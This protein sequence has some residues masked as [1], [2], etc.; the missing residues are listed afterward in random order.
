MKR[1]GLIGEAYN[2]NTTHM[3]YCSD[4]APFPHIWSKSAFSGK[5][6]YM[7]LTEV[8]N[9][10]PVFATRMDQLLFKPSDG[11]KSALSLSS[12]TYFACEP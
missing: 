2:L 12:I 10:V 5:G 1:T 8:K 9:G 11:I 6:Q 7:V 4:D 3:A